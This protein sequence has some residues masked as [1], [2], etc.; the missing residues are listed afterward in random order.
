MM[1]SARNKFFDILSSSYELS[2]NIF[3]T[4]AL[5]VDV[6]PTGCLGKLGMIRVAGQSSF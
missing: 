5:M 2:G 6:W 3:G 4:S 1:G